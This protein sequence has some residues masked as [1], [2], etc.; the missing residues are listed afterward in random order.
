M[1]RPF[2]PP[3]K[4]KTPRLAIL[5]TV[6]ALSGTS[7]HAAIISWGA[8]TNISGDGD[9]ST[10]GTM[11]GAFNVGGPAT[12]VNGVNF[13]AFGVGATSNTDGNFNLSSSS[14]IGANSFS[15]A[16]TPFSNLSASY[17]SLIS[18][19]ANSGRLLTLT[20]GG[21]TVGQ[22]Y[23][24]Q[25]WVNESQSH[26]PPGFTFEVDVSSGSLITLDPNT[27]IFEGGLGQYVVGTFTASAASQQVTYDN[28]EVGG[29]LAAFQLRAAAP[30]AVPEP[31][32][33]LFGLALLGA[34][35]CTRRRPS[36]S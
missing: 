27:T 33:A 31:G 30:P 2:H 20:L 4:M 14:V 35:G 21:L 24:F 25:T 15:T 19:G 12:T 10:N 29:S 5:L 7:L 23:I 18:T 34:T 16:L 6:A 13:Q 1:A 28:S 8:P 32:T 22:T 9:V 17:R 36:R 26:I 11:L 3:R